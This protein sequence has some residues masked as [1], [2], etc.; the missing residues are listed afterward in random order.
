[1]KSGKKLK[2][3]IV[4]TFGSV[5]VETTVPSPAEVRR[6]IRSGQRAL[7]RALPCLLKPG[8]SLNTPPGVPIFYADREDPE[9]IIRE[10]DGILERGRIVNGAFSL[11][12]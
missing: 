12:D 4:V 5:T 10:M 8:V 11:L 9:V 1:M 3:K 7:Q 6:N 2:K